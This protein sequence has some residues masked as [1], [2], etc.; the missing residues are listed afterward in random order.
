MLN[1]YGNEIKTGINKKLAL[2]THFRGDT[3]G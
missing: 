1:T 2:R 3:L